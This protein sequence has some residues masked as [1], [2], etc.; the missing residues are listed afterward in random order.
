MEVPVTHCEDVP[1]PEFTGLPDIHDELL[2]EVSTTDNEEGEGINM[3]F[4]PT[5]D[6]LGNPIRLSQLELN[7]LVRDLYLPKQY[8][9]L[10]ASRLNE[11]NLLSHGTSVTYYRSREA[12]FWKYLVRNDQL[13]YCKDIKGR[14]L[15][16]SVTYVPGDWRLFIDSSKW[17][18]KCVLLHNNGNVYGSIPI[19][20]SV[21][22]KGNHCCVKLVL[23]SL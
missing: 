21:E 3:Q 4:P 15:E 8:A 10:L 18:L 11:K 7:D 9:E 1:V 19:G 5:D 20:D 6:L 2:S 17:T 16:M 22:L 13:V 14:L 12:S 23:D